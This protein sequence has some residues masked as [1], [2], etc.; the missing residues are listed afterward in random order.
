MDGRLHQES[1]GNHRPDSGQELAH[2]LEVTTD[3]T[4]S[5]DKDTSWGQPSQLLEVEGRPVEDE[6]AMQHT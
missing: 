6:V 2:I 1:H 5:A 3:T 4:S